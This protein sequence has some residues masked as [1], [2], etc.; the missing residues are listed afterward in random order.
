MN[1]G[2]LRKQALRKLHGTWCS[3]WY[4]ASGSVNGE[5]LQPTKRQGKSSADAV[6]AEYC[7]EGDGHISAFLTRAV[8]DEDASAIA[9]EISAVLSGSGIELL[10]TM[11]FA[12]LP[13]SLARIVREA[14]L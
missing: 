12:A 8:T 1:G 13:E 3:W 5:L 11:V 7:V 14:G 10:D 4:G 6:C 9:E 2:E